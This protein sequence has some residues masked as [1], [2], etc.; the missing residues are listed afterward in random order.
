[1][2]GPNGTLSQKDRG[3]YSGWMYSVN[4]AIPN[5]VMAQYYLS[6]GDQILFFYTDD[7][8]KISGM[9]K[10]AVT[11]DEVIRLIDEIGHGDAPPRRRHCGGAH[12]LR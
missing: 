3:E 9:A 4:G 1:M 8:T 12:G 5:V 6:D 2:S 11:V 7:Y 10:P